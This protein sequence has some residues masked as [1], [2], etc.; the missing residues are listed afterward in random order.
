MGAVRVRRASELLTLPVRHNGIDLGRAVDLVLDLGA[1]R[2]LGLEVRCRDDAHRFL[3]LGA[4]RL[5]ADATEVGSPLS[6]I[7]DLAFY[8]ARGTPFRELRGVEMARAGA[9]LGMI[10]DVL[11]AGDG[12][13]ASV[14]VG[15]P[16]GEVRLA[17]SPTLSLTRE[18]RAS[19]A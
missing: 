5:H 1:G 10:A 12:A 8:R 2:A 4:A 11:V 7:D 13:I 9:P 14:V 15:T 6:L 19:A 18:R 17:F 3:P 16:A